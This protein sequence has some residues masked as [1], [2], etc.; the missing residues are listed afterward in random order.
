MIGLLEHGVALAQQ[1][2]HVDIGQGCFKFDAGGHLAGLALVEPDHMT[3][4]TRAIFAPAVGGIE[5]EAFDGFLAQ[6]LV[7][8]RRT[9]RDAGPDVPYLLGRS[10][11]DEEIDAHPRIFGM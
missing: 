11:R 6:V 2:D 3:G 5:Y 10:A 8:M 9:Y 4:G 7:A 1:L